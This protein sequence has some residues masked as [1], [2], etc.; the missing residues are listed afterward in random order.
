MSK[1]EDKKI[2]ELVHR[3]SL[4]STFELDVKRLRGT[5]GIPTDGLSSAKESALW[6]IESLK[7]AIIFRKQGNSGQLPV[8]F[9]ASRVEI[10]SLLVKYELPPSARALVENYVL[11]GNR[12]PS[13]VSD[14]FAIAMD[15]G[16]T[17][18][19]DIF[20]TQ[21]ALWRMNNEKYVRL[22]IHEGITKGSVRSFLDANWD[23]I[24]RMLTAPDAPKAKRIRT[25]PNKERD[26][27]I[28][29]FYSKPARE[30]GLKRGEQKD[31]AVARMLMEQGYRCSPEIVR[32]VASH[33][34]QKRRGA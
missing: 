26:T 18:P 23:K 9:I 33:E 17:N 5:L 29:E 14:S 2:Q 25:A 3:A 10:M 30:L 27:L 21:E 16:Y 8:R 19:T 4:K 28:H 22:L 12:F 24:Q 20:T 11:N 34:Q 31:I 6:E 1:T 15:M 32:K 13:A 7:S